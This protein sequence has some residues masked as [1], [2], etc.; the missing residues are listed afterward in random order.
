MLLCSCAYFL[1][2]SGGEGF[3]P[4][5][6]FL[7]F[8]HVSFYLWFRHLV[9]YDEQGSTFCNDSSGIVPFFAL[10]DGFFC[11]CSSVWDREVDRYY[12]SGSDCWFLGLLER[13]RWGLSR[14]RVDGVNVR[15]L[16]AAPISFRHGDGFRSF[17]RFGQDSFRFL[18]VRQYA[19]P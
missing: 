9:S 7:I 12:S 1:I 18:L 13:I 4:I 5:P 3:S 10:G 14:T 11:R 2:L 6:I 16:R 19:P 15:L 17:H 8:N